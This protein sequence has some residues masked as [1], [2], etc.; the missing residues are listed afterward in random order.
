MSTPT[1]N[2]TAT[3][4][5][6]A[7]PPDWD[8]CA[9]MLDRME[10]VLRSI[11]PEPIGEWMRAQGTP[12][13]EWTLVLPTKYRETRQGPAIWPSYVVFSTILEQPV[14]LHRSRVGL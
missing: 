9:S 8:P 7:T 12:P 6:T 13:E 3:T 10:S 2:F 11:P 4:C 5:T 1:K 14:V